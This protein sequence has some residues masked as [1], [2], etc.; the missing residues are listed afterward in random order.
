M[1]SEEPAQHTV[2]EDAVAPL[3]VPA[4]STATV[5]AT[6]TTNTREATVMHT[7][8]FSPHKRKRDASPLEVP[9]TPWRLQ[10][11]IS[12][13]D[14]DDHDHDHDEESVG[15]ELVVECEPVA[16]GQVSPR[17]N[18]LASQLSDLNLSGKLVGL[19][20]LPPPRDLEITMTLEEEPPAAKKVKR[21]GR[22]ANRK[23]KAAVA[24][25]GNGDGSDEDLATVVKRNGKETLSFDEGTVN[26]NGKEVTVGNTRR[27]LRSPPLPITTGS[28]A[29]DNNATVDESDNG[30][31]SDDPDQLGIGY[32]PTLMQRHARDRKRMQ[33]V[34]YVPRHSLQFVGGF[35]C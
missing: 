30:V 15:V 7:G 9:E 20:P 14:D 23:K 33:Q 18:G 22:P 10:H 4:T 8:F 13:D 25:G 31:D 26:G 16:S 1:G 34:T 11:S 28:G 19:L 2:I 32:K 35:F 27:R 12:H 6:T 5:M 17:S 3:H 29:S 24:A 21:R